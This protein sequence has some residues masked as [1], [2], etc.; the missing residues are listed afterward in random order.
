MD[1][2]EL[3]TFIET[4]Q[5]KEWMTR[6]KKPLLDKRDELLGELKAV[7]G[8]LAEAS[9]RVADS[10]KLLS[11]ERAAIRKAV[12]DAPL[13]AM[14]EKIGAPLGVLPGVIACHFAQY[15]DSFS[16]AFLSLTIC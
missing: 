5:G 9:Q 7:N 14:L 16:Q 2:K 15:S 4:D 6:H 8:R 3:D 11:E 10:E 1:I 12:V 13:T